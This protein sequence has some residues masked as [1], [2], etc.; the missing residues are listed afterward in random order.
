MKVSVIVPVYKL[1]LMV[2][3]C[4]ESIRQQRTGFDVEILV[5][6][7]ASPDD[8][9]ARM[10]VEAAK[11]DRIRLYRNETNRG[12]AFNQQFLLAQASGEY[13][14]YMD[15]DDIAFPGKLSALADYLDSHPGCAI[16]YHEADVFDHESNRSLY[17]YSRDHYNARYVPRVAT[18][19][20]L[21]KY[22][23]FLNA[24]ATMFRRHGN[25]KN[26]VDDRCRILLDYPMHI[27]NA[28]HINGTI[29]R[30]DTVLGRYRLHAGSSCGQNA[31]SDQ[32]R[33]RV[34]D[35]Q[36]QA[37]QNA[38]QFGVDEKTIAQGKAH[39]RFA[40]A[41]FF[42]K[43]GKHRLFEDFIVRASEEGCYFDGRHRLA[44]E[45]RKEPNRVYDM[46]FGAAE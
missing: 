15:G 42:L 8:S 13:I 30:I 45:F 37:V 40:A 43:K 17:L 38:E 6:D 26:I 22:G 29:D 27:L 46:L 44:F 16:V 20:H 2:T 7:D 33:I 31:Q 21:V 28:G 41:L 39:H 12:L 25:L 11:D 3:E 35:D 23:C 1:G 34:V 24:S 4:L 10:E 14:A 19:E 18:I 9:W 36:V 5:I 32:R